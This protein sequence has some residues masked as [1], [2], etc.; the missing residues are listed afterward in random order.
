MYVRITLE[1]ETKDYW[2]FR[3]EGIENS[4]YDIS[5]SQ[6]ANALIHLEYWQNE[7]QLSNFSSK[8]FELIS[9]ADKENLKK[10]FKGFPARVTAYILWYQSVNKEELNRYRGG[11]DG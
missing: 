11:I 10:I 9:K 4:V 1:N 2:T 7:H 5:K 6:L 8:L 3:E